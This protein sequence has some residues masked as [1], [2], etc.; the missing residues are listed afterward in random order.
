MFPTIIR[1][2]QV[3]IVETFG[4]FTRIVSPGLRWYIPLVQKITV[5]S[6]RLQQNSFEYVVKTKDNVFTTL[7][8]NV[9]Y[10]ILGDDAAT[11]Y[12]ALQEPQ[13]Q[14]EAYIE[15]TVRAKVPT[16]KLDELFESQ[17]DI[18]HSVSET[19]ENEMAAYGYT[20]ESTLIT[21]IEPAKEVKEAMNRIN[22]SERIKE[23]SKNEAE[24]EYIKKVREAEADRDRKRLQGEGMSQ[25][26]LAILEGYEKGVE[27]MA[28]KLG[29]TSKDIINFVLKS[30]YL[31]TIHSIGHSPNTKTIFMKPENDNV[32]ESV[33]LANEIGK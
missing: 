6:T 27:G 32:F 10:R 5:M 14:F 24:A 3:G 29:L 22:A 28:K 20:I 15:N 8:V 2:A 25:Q 11:A 33:S 30:Q 31:D 13:F 23:A 12:Y 9:Q 17:N 16:L 26:R 19:L 7:G 1:S 18:S 21:K 4:K